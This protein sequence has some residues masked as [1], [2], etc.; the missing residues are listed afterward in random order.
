MVTWTHQWARTPDGRFDKH[1]NRSR[2][3]FHERAVQPLAVWMNLQIVVFEE[4]LL[5]FVESRLCTCNIHVFRYSH[6]SSHESCVFLCIPYLCVVPRARLNYTDCIMVY[7]TCMQIKGE[8]ADKDLADE[9]KFAAMVLDRLCL[10]L[11]LVYFTVGTLVV[12]FR[13]PYYED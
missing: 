10:W 13:R 4:S 7:C 3:M 6:A 5:S 11:F 2:R 1:K 9:W 12:Y 8:V